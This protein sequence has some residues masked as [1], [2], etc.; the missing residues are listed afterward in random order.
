[1]KILALDTATENCSAALFINGAFLEREQLLGRGA[2]EVILVMVQALLAEAELSLRDLDAVAF[3]RGPGGFTGVRLAAS[4]T[5]G[6]AFGAGLGVVGISDLRALA[7][8]ALGEDPH[9]ARVLTCPDA[10]MREVYCGAFERAGDL[11]V[12][13]APERVV[14]PQHVS[15]PEAWSASVRALGVGSGFAAYPE[16]AAALAGQLSGV[17]ADLLPRARE[18]ACLAAPEVA[19]GRLATPEQALPVYLRDDVTQPPPARRGGSLI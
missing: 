3:G 6:L 8:R 5:Q 17:R 12:P 18:I 2:A 7:Q 10:R 16:L 15:L 4:V 1:V 19:A 14:A 11:A 13:V 9:C